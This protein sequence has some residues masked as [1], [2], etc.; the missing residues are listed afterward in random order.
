M[1]GCMVVVVVVVVSSGSRTVV[2]GSTEEGR[3]CDLFCLMFPLS[4]FGAW[5]DQG[6]E[7]AL[8]AILNLILEFFLVG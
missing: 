4:D 3:I 5:R 7:L 6:A 8:E 1:Y 2:V